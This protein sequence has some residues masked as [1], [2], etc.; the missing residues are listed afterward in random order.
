MGFHNPNNL[1]QVKSWSDDVCMQRRV[2]ETKAVWA[3]LPHAA[4]FTDLDS[5]RCCHKMTAQVSDQICAARSQHRKI[6]LVHRTT[7]IGRLRAKADACQAANAIQLLVVPVDGALP[8][9]SKQATAILA[10]KST[11]SHKT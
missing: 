6:L 11:A 4:G 5:K 9:W 3:G 2:H 7:K 1:L 8:S 10:S